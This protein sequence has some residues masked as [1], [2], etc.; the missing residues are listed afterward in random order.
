MSANNANARGEFLQFPVPSTVVS[1]DPILV[2]AMAA[3]AQ[4]SYTPPGSVTP[5]GQ[6]S[7]A[8]IGCFF[9]SVTAKSSL[10]PSVGSA[11]KPGDKLYLDGGTLDSTTNV[12]TGGTLDKN[13]GGTFF[14]FACDAITSGSTATIR[15]RLKVGD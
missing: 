12:T 4:E 14:G 1:G 10:S 3:V 9:L 15:V 8:L 11:V 2:G 13:T 6:V 5:T 7:V